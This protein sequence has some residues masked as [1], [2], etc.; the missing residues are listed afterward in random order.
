MKNTKSTP[1]KPL[2]AQRRFIKNM[3]AI[4]VIL[5][6]VAFLAVSLEGYNHLISREKIQKSADLIRELSVDLDGKVLDRLS[7]RRSFSIR[8]VDEYFVNLLKLENLEN[9]VSTE[10]AETRQ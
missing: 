6:L 2:E 7:Q 3:I 9:I 10:S 5:L 1:D 4:S 8:E